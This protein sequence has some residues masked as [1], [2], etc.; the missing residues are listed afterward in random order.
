MKNPIILVNVEN[1]AQR[2]GA[3]MKVRRSTQPGTVTLEM[4][5]FDEDLLEKGQ[6]RKEPLPIRK[7]VVPIDFS[8]FSYKSLDYASAFAAQSKAEI[9]LLHVVPVTYVDA[10]LV[11][12]DYTEIEKQTAEAA[13]VR[14]EKL[15]QER[16]VPELKTSIRVPVGRAVDEIVKT[17]EEFEADLIIMSTHGY[18]GIKHAFLG[19]TTENVVRYAPCPVLTLRQREHDFVSSRPETENSAALSDQASLS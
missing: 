3:V 16:I 6:P 18:T 19:S 2:K 8:P 13:K 1:T 7:I 9:L 10:D 12:F 15:V 11:A 14:L 17:A 5:R 4:H